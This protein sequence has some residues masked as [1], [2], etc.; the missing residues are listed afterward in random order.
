MRPE[1][2]WLHVVSDAL[3]ATAY[4]CILVT[5][6]CFVRKRRD[7][8]YHWMFVLFGFFLFACGVAH[9]MEIWSVWHGTYRLSGVVK[10]ATAVAS[11]VTLI[12]LIRLLPQALTLPAPEDLRRTNI[13]LESE[14]AEREQAETALAAE[15][16]NFERQVKEHAEELLAVKDEL[17]AEQEAM[18]RL[19]EFGTRMPATTELQPLLEE[20]LT[21][22]IALQS[23]DFGT[24]QL[25][26]PKSQALE[27]VAQ[28]GFRQ[29]FLDHFRSVLEGEVAYGARSES[30]RT[31]HHR[32][33]FDRRGF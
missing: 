17:A 7:L 9:L 18:T 4:F 29:D 5:L 25:Y 28:R 20:V 14:I 12:L 19:H 32:G 26:N 23:A 24:I 30:R 6:A 10:A 15:R 27:I 13:A 33:R 16:D 3:I 2:I 11:M 22:S 31:R 8:P 21:A 1:I